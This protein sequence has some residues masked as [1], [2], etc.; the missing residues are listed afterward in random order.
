M[1]IEY[2]CNYCANTISLTGDVCWDKTNIKVGVCEKCSLKQLYNFSH[3]GLDYYSA[4]D[5]FTE[6][7]APLRK[8]EYH[9]NQK[10][11]ERLVSYLPGVESK[12]VLDFGSGHG[13]FLEQA[14]GKFQDIYG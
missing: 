14:N 5:H 2:K 1:T 12:K 11:V 8:R 10:R 13:G 7:L 3:V 4:D 6:D 9:W